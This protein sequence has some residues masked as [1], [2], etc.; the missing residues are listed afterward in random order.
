MTTQHD[1]AR[2]L[3]RRTL[4]KGAAWSVPVIAAASAAPATAASPSCEPAINW[5]GGIYYDY[6]N[7]AADRL[8]GS[9]RTKRSPWADSRK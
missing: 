7:I 2:P 4:A 3:T 5:G 9:P 8:A 1:D 6:G